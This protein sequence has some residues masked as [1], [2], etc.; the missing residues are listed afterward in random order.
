MRVAHAEHLPPFAEV[1]SG[2]AVGLVVDIFR[3]AAE[4]VGRSVAFVA[5]PFEQME[6]ALA[7]GRAELALPLAVTSERRARLD[8]TATL[9]VTGGSLYVRAPVPAPAGLPAVAGKTVVTPRT[10]PLADYIRK[11]APD[12]RLLVCE[13]YEAGLAMLVGGEVDAAAL[14]HQAGAAIATRLFPGRVTLP[15]RMFLELPF[16]AA[17]LKGRHPDLLAAVDRGIAEIRADG[18]L[19]RIAD[20]P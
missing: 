2:R 18:T 17:A 20:A 7:S 6:P 8:F 10:G 1:R 3:A 16:A 15:G 11:H 14:N 5:V 4:R 12:V 19:E 13:D 9:L